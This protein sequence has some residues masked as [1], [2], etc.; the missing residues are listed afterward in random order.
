[1]ARSEAP[2]G[3]IP[4]TWSAQLRADRGPTVLDATGV[5]PGGDEDPG[6]VFYDETYDMPTI[7]LR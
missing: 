5:P 4:C 2:S 1:M 3:S 6:F 7:N